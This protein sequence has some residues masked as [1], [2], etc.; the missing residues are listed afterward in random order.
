MVDGI[1]TDDH[2]PLPNRFDAAF[3][4]SI[5][6]DLLLTLFHKF[7]TTNQHI[8]SSMVVV[9]RSD[10]HKIY[11]AQITCDSDA[12][13]NIIYI[14]T[15]LISFQIGLLASYRRVGKNTYKKN[16]YSYSD[17]FE[18]CWRKRKKRQR[19]R[20]AVATRVPCL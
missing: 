14:S 20:A 10:Y 1:A 19:R 6:I 11:A 12:V 13:S 15:T 17:Q 16:K 4:H 5:S 18:F 3:S 2:H 8:P 9:C 7:A